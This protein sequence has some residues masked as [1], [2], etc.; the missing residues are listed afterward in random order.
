MPLNPKAKQQLKA[1]AHALKPVVSIGQN[2]LTEAV[3][4]ELDSSLLFHELMKVKLQIKDRDQR[5]EIMNEICQT[6][7]AES[8]QL[9]GNIAVIYRRNPEKIRKT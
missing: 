3:N 1:Q 4:K 9:I 5:R 2:G 6:H 8:I 7:Q